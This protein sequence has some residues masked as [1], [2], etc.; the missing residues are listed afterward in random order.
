MSSRWSLASRF[1]ISSWQN[2]LERN[3]HGFCGDISPSVSKG[4]SR[5][6]S[7]PPGTGWIPARTSHPDISPSPTGSA[8]TSLLGVPATLLRRLVS[9]GV[10]LSWGRSIRFRMGLMTLVGIEGER[11]SCRHLLRFTRRCAGRVCAAAWGS[12]IPL[13]PPQHHEGGET[14]VPF[15]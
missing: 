3:S 4:S 11:K 12:G 9:T 8:A 6:R 10:S 7:V 13:H 2:D 14:T 15:W 5:A 1:S